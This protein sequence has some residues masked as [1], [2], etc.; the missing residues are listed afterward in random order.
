MILLVT[1]SE[2]AGE[3]SAALHGATGEEIRVAESLAL[4]TTLLRAECYRVVV[5][6]QYLL[7]T[8]SRE[9]EALGFRFLGSIGI[10]HVVC[11]KGL[12]NL[13]VKKSRFLF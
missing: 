4:A 11:E 13:S 9:A 12:N 8:E 7:E 6:D 5:F 1:P 2:R 10:F 3:C